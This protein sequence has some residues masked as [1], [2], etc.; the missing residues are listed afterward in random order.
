MELAERFARDQGAPQ[1]VGGVTVHNIFRQPVAEGSR[2]L[3]HRLRVADGDVQGLRI[4]VHGGHVRVNAQR[5]AEVVLW[6]DTSPEQVEVTCETGGEVAEFRAWNCWRD[7]NGTMQAWLGNSGMVV[8][9]TGSV[10]FLRC[11]A[12]YHEFS[13]TDLEVELSFR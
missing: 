5:L 10:V 4:K 6:A 2:V 1:E 7:A 12:G 13:P 9:K 3:V 11:S 8:E